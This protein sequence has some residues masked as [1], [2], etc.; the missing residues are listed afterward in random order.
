[1]T[2]VLVIKANPK[3]T[4][5]SHSLT[6]LEHF[7]TSYLQLHTNDTVVVRDLYAEKFPDF[8]RD[9]VTAQRALSA[10]K[11]FADLPDAQQTRLTQFRQTTQQ[12]IDADK[13][14][15]ANPLWNLMIPGK[16]KAWFDTVCVEGQTFET[17]AVG[18][19]PLAPGKQ[20]LHIQAAG[21]ITNGQNLASRYVKDV[22]TFLGADVTAL[23][24]EGMDRYPKRADSIMAEA[25]RTADE[26][27][28]V[29]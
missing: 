12:F 7:L 13:V 3:P 24:V 8:D 22:M 19:R 18:E 17:V 9:L 1:M 14:I 2:T 11:T 20:V 26:I 28:T 29:F 21:G 6:V 15:I 25:F 4:S 10:G 16:L 5:A 27:A 23:P